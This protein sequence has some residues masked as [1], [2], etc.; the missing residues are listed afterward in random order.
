MSNNNDDLATPPRSL[1]EARFDQDRSDA[2][3]LKCWAHRHWCKRKRCN[4]GTFRLNLNRAKEDVPHESIA[5]TRDERNHRPTRLLDRLDQPGLGG[6]RKRAVVDAYDGSRVFGPFW[7]NGDLLVCSQ[8]MFE[9]SLT[10]ALQPRWLGIP[11]CRRRVQAL[12]SRLHVWIPLAETR[13][14]A[15]GYFRCMLSFDDASR[16]R[17][18]LHPSCSVTVPL[19]VLPL[20]VNCPSVSM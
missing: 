19:S 17:T 4:R 15:P 20:S 12:V 7:T 18:P 1:R 2:P 8:W 5:G 10:I 11:P 9:L 3:P 14:D 6:A 13:R 16:R